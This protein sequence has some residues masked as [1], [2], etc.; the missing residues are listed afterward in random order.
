MANRHVVD[1]LADIRSEIKNLR[2]REQSLRAEVLD[3]PDELSGDQNETTILELAVERLD[4]EQLKREVG[5]AFLRPFLRQQV[6]TRVMLRPVQ[7]KTR[8]AK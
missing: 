8:G 3:N 1:R 2:E 6:Q 5:M 7:T 4:V